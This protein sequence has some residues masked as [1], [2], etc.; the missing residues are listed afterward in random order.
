VEKVASIKREDDFSY[1]TTV[2]PKFT[3]DRRGTKFDTDTK[4][5]IYIRAALA[6]VP[7]CG[8]CGGYVHVNSISIDH[9]VRR[10]D[11][12]RDGK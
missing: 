1:L 11:G 4:S 8:I 6:S 9:K 7:R 5:E 2:R 3:S 10:R 12:G